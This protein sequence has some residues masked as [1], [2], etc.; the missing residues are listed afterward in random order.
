MQ[1]N[2]FSRKSPM[3]SRASAPE[4]S[5]EAQRHRQ[6]M[7]ALTG[8]LLGMFVS[9]LAGTVVGTSLP[10][11]INELGGDQAAF[12]WVITANLLATTVATPIWGKFAD[13]FSRKLLM[14]LAISGFTLASI[15]AGFAT[16]T[17]DLIFWRVLPSAR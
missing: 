11:I 14:Q 3:S 9:M 12:T 15:G 1:N 10:R 13:M 7:Q 6:V 2:Y 5:D 17:G 4:L 16:G 8:L